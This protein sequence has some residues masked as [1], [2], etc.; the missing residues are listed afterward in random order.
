[1]DGLTS[2]VGKPL[3]YAAGHLVQL[4]LPSLWCR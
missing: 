2:V 1:L 3:L 4:S